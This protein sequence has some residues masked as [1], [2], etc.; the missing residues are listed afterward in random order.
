MRIIAVKICEETVSDGGRGLRSG[1]E[2]RSDK[3]EMRACAAVLQHGALPNTVVV[4][5][6]HYICSG[7]LFY[8]Y[9]GAFMVVLL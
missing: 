8:S 6:W 5:M 7:D 9:T 2:G 3:C 4:S 1:R